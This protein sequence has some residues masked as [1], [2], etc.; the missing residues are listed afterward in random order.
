MTEKGLSYLLKIKLANRHSA[1]KKLKEQ[2]EKIL[3]LRDSPETEIEQLEGEKFYLDHLKDEFND[4][5]KEYDDLLE[6]KEEKEA[7]YRWFDIRDREFFECRRKICKHIQALE[8]NSASRK[9]KASGK[10]MLSSSSTKH[11]SLALIDAAAKATKLQAEMEFLEK[12][13]ELRRLQIEKELAIASA[14]ESAIKRILEEERLSGERDATNGV[15][16]KQELKPDVGIQ[17]IKEERSYVNPLAPPFI[18]RSHPS[19]RALDTEACN[20]AA[21]PG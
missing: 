8:R 19:L 12:E 7:S 17:N 16:V 3:E 11:L 6:L 14:E 5:H 1:L 9:S 4:A 13:K 21:F 15:G 20:Y 18:P 2:M 10:S